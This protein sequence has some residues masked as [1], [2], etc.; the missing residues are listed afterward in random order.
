MAAVLLYVCSAFVVWA[1]LW[2]C[3]AALP[4]NGHC[5][6]SCDCL[7]ILIDCSKKGLVAV[8]EDLHLRSWG[9]QLELQS[10]GITALGQDD[11]KGLHKLEELFL[12]N[13]DI[14]YINGSIFSDLTSLQTL[15]ITHNKLTE[16]PVFP[17][18][19]NITDLSL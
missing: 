19:L 1:V 15:K 8:P 6:T 7:G 12:N 9:K 3:F 10:N 4:N 13:N 5:P 14:T 17:R 11:F 18:G 16:M 2:P